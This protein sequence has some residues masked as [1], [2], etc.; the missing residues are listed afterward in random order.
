MNKKK[1]IENQLSQ[2]YINENI[3]SLY[4]KYNKLHESNYAAN[5]FEKNVNAR[6]DY[7]SEGSKLTVMSIKKIIVS[8]IMTMILAGLTLQLYFTFSLNAF[9]I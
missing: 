8:V 1:K 5:T 4:V 9:M 2:E 7:S 3:D 6:K